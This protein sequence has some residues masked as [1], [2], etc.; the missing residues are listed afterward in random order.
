MPSSRPANF[1]PIV[2]FSSAA[3]RLAMPTLRSDCVAMMLRVRPAQLS[4]SRVSAAGAA[5]GARSTTST[6]G[7][8]RPIGMFMVAY[9]SNLRTSTT[10]TSPP[11][12]TSAWSRSGAMKGTPRR[13]ATS[14]PK[15]LLGA[16]T[17][18]NSS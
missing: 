16:L 14:S 7:A 3:T 8:L 9:S 12:M 13:H 5:S 15:A 17:S 1:Q 18:L 6:P 2:P 10:A 4:T 11:A